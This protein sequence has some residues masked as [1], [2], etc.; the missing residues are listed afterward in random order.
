MKILSDILYKCPL[1]HVVGSTQLGIKS[2]DFDSRTAAESSLFVAIDGLTVDGHDYIDKAISKGAIAVMCTVLPENIE[3]GI[4]YVV[5]KNTHQALGQAASNFYDNPTEKLRVI[6]VTGT[7]GKTTTATLMYDLAT[8]MGIKCGLLSTVINKIGSET[9]PATFT[10]PDAVSMNELFAEMV[11]SDCLYCFMEAS[12]H[13]IHQQRISG[14]SFA[15]AVFTNISHDHLDYHKSFSEYIKAKKCLFDNLGKS[16]FA[17]V[18]EDD[19]HG[20]VM[21]QNCR[22]KIR[23]FG[24]KT[25]ADYKAKVIE[26]QFNGLHLN[27]QGTEVYSR[28]IGGFNAYNLLAVYGVF[29]E[30]GYESIDVL[31]HLS[32]LQAVEGRFEYIKSPKGTIAIIDYAH[33]PDALK[34]VLKTINE[35]RTGNEKVITVVGCG[36]DRDREKRPIMAR[37]AGELSNQL[38]LTSDNPRSEEPQDILGEMNQGLDPILMKKSINMVDRREAIKLACTLANVGDIILIAGK[39]HEKYQEI[40]GEKIPFD[41]YKIVG[42]TFKMLEK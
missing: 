14:I 1:E 20:D 29:M 42:Q 41:D 17:L 34:N 33:T 26:N 3:P 23:T 10:T 7:N 36:G 32:S 4:T 30:L 25:M 6:A 31:T 37:I 15:G 24:L 35:I 2:I 40:K 27:I 5:V 12:S 19:T 8:A 9:K 38:I 13:A 11:E 18:N 39:G 21:V 28:L 22:A 16:A